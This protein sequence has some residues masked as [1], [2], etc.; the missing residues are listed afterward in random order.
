MVK[1]KVDCRMAAPGDAAGIFSVLV[2]AAPEIPL[3]VDTAERREAIAKIINNCIAT[4][5]SQVATV[6]CG[7]VAG[8]I[9]V[10]PDE[11]EH[12]LYE[13][14]ALHLRY[15]GVTKAYRQQGIF[16]SL[17]KQ[18]MKRGVPLTATVKATNQ[19]QMAIL[20][21]KF[22]FQ[23]CSGYSEIEDQFKW[24]PVMTETIP[25]GSEW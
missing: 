11:M 20:L 19:C 25:V 17:V 6:S 3:F 14:H 12:F 16:R 5:E 7:A 24:Q 21:E 9:L 2:E 15:V 1:V 23:H 4:G 18:V 22:G 13:N 8:V 10:E